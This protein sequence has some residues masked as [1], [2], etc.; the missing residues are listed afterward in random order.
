MLRFKWRNMLRACVLPVII[1]VMPAYIYAAQNYTDALSKSIYYY[2]AQRCGTTNSWIHGA[3]HTNDGSSVGI[4]LSG[5]WHDCGDHV[6]FGQTNAYSAAL[7]LLAFSYFS[8]AYQDIYT[9]TDTAGSDGIP[10][11]L[12]E[13]KVETDY[14]LKAYN[15]G[16]VYYQ[17]GDGAADHTHF[18]TPEY[19]STAYATAAGGD[20]RNCYSFTSGG[21]NV[22]GTA[23]AALAL[24]FILYKQYDAAYA[25]QCSTTAV[26]YYNVGKTNPAAISDANGGSFYSASHWAGHMAWGAIELYRATGTTSYLTD[27]QTYTSNG[28]YSM[29]T[30]W[31]LCWNNCEPAADFELY[32]MTGTATYLTKM[33]SEV[34][35]YESKMTTCGIGSYATVNSWGNLRYTANMALCGAFLDYMTTGGD[36]TALSMAKNST[37]F[38]L[39]THGA[40]TSDGSMA[41]PGAAQGESFLV[42]YTNP[43]YTSAGCVLHPHHR[44]AFGKTTTGDTDFTTEST[45]PGSVAYLHQLVGSLPGGPINNCSGFEDNIGKY[46]VTEGGIDYNAGVVGALAYMVLKYGTPATT[47]TFT[48]TTGAVATRTFTPT[49]TRTVTITPSQTFTGTRTNTPSQTFTYTATPTLTNTKTFTPTATPSYTITMTFTTVILSATDTPTYTATPTATGTRTFSPTPTFTNTI[50]PTSTQTRTYTNT[51]TPTYTITMTFTI[52]ILS[53]TNT[54]TYTATGTNTATR[55]FTFTYTQTGTATNTATLTATPTQTNTATPTITATCTHTPTATK[56]DTLTNTASPTFTATQTLTSTPTLTYTSTETSTLTETPTL[57]ITQ[58]NT[59]SPTITETYTG[60]PPTSTDTST[61]T[62]TF[63][64]TQTETPSFTYTASPTYTETSSSTLTQSPTLTYT[65]SITATLTDT[66]TLTATQTCTGTLKPAFTATATTYTGTVTPTVIPTQST[67]AILNPVI[68]PNP[69]NPT[70]SGDLHIKFQITQEIKNISLKIYTVAF[71]LVKEE[72]WEGDFQAGEIEEDIAPGELYKLAN[73]TYYFLLT[74]ETSDG[75]T[76]K[77]K[78]ATIIILR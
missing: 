40:I 25:A 30:N 45:T 66:I 21:S 19:E 47:P 78:P 22:C 14:L 77:G 18:V 37:D 70:G 17:V 54:P 50:S 69:Y 1:A 33:Q 57:T 73:G 34:S 65:Y 12:N 23:A 6:K 8:S 26:E 52:V 3:C 75:K 41:G 74:A 51:V 68:Y 24:M 43:D 27:A 36:T 55:T 11:L 35:S 13:V 9:A 49:P 62:P 38:I 63:T 28:D 39:G 71:R 76:L 60:T 67:P 56:S 59:E 61:I 46:E 7:L 2:G 15:G 10:D 29:P 53:A 64:I 32:K 58:T 72:T 31:V 48:F 44:A 20:P 4:D 42:G 16:K 5:G